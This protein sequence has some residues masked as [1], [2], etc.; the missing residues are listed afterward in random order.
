VQNAAWAARCKWYDIGVEL[1]LDMS[2]L[3]TININCREVMED[4]FREALGEWL[5][6]VSPKASWEVAGALESPS[7]GYPHL[8]DKIRQLH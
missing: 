1:G 2:T 3:D 8:A 4:C 5:K 6:N 7:V